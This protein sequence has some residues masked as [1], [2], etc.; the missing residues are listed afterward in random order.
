[1]I[2]VLDI[3]KWKKSWSIFSSKEFG[4]AS[5]WL[6]NQ[7]TTHC[8][9][10]NFGLGLFFF[11]HFLVCSLLQGLSCSF[12]KGPLGKS[13]MFFFWFP[14]GVEEPP[15]IQP[16]NAAAEVISAALNIALSM[17]VSGIPWIEKEQSN[18]WQ[19]CFWLWGFP[20]MVVPNNHGFSY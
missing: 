9:R 17:R 8:S 10:R 18:L 4:M 12:F 14:F 13:S 15:R 6:R 20:K 2:W 1:M 5:N 3:Q 16:L 7:Q 11:F 19:G